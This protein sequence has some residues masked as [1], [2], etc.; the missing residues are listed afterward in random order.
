MLKRVETVRTNFIIKDFIKSMVLVWKDMYGSFPSKKS[1]AVL[2]A[3]WSLETG[4]GAS[5][6][7]N[8]LGNIKAKDTEG[9]VIEYCVLKGVWEIVNGKKIILPPEDPG[10]WFRSFPTL[11]EGV[12]FHF[13]FLKNKRYKAAW[14]AVEEGDYKKF[15]SLLRKQGYYTASEEDYAKGM[16]GYY[17]N[18]M[19]GKTFDTVIAELNQP[20]TPVLPVEPVPTAPEPISPIVDPFELPETVIVVEPE[21]TKPIV[22]SKFNMQKV[23]DMLFNLLKIFFHIK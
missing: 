5:C 17:N 14:V 9:E 21:P 8:N 19:N 22:D 7:N 16:S 6:W 13:N 23:L 15:A 2:F 11:T 18:F 20:I 12:K 3:Q 4:Q 1:L 10:S